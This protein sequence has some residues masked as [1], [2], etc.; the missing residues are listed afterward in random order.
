[1]GIECDQFLRQTRRET[2]FLMFGSNLSLISNQLPISLDFPDKQDEFNEIIQLY[3]KRMASILNTK[4]GGLYLPIEIATFKQFFT[5]G[6]PQKFRDVYRKEF[7]MVA[8]NGGPIAPGAVLSFPH[9]IVGI[10]EL[11]LMQGTATN[12]NRFLLP[13][14]YVNVVLTSSIQIDMNDTNIYLV[15]GSTQLTLTKAY[16]TAEYVKTS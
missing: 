12:I 13:L 16:I 7:D 5:P 1:M 11:T 6:N 14:P 2:H 10:T 15:N 8:L 3:L 9:N 4:E